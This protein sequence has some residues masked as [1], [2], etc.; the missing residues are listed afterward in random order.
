MS[1][2]RE[3]GTVVKTM[4]FACVHFTVAF[5]IAYLLTGSVALSGALA[6]IEPMANTVA[7]Y[8]HER[9]WRRIERREQTGSA[10]PATAV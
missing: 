9:V 4:T 2:I 8:L 3:N 10:A 6:L 5:S 1:V 7:Y